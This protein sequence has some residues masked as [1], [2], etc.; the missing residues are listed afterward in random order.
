ML[1]L[2]YINIAKVDRDVVHV[3]MAIHVCFKCMF[4]MFHLFQT[5]V[6][7]VS[8]GCYKSRSGCCKSKSGCCIYMH[9]ASI[10]FNCFQV[11]LSGCCICLQWFQMLFRRFHKWF[12][13]LFSTVSFVFFYMLQLLQY[14][15]LKIDRTLHMGCAWDPPIWVQVLNL[16]HVLVFSWFIPGFNGAMLSVV[17]HVPVDNETLVVWW[18]RES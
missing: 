2:L 6:A 14:D 8:S 5:N 15:V 3:V 12:R 17:C 1:Q 9:V 13:H 7:S 18:L 16:A 4:Q 10:C 11:F